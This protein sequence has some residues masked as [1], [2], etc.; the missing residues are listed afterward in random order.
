MTLIVCFWIMHL[1]NIDYQSNRILNPEYINYA[2]YN[3][4]YDTA[5]LKQ[6]LPS[7]NVP[8]LQSCVASIRSMGSMS[9]EFHHFYGQNSGLFQIPK[10]VPTCAGF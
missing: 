1:W 6:T 9:N 3:L 5:P 2:N 8:C 10:D 7:D 4:I